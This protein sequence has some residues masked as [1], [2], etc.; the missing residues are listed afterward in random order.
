MEKADLLLEAAK[1]SL[2][3]G[4]SNLVI[5]VDEEAATTIVF[6]DDGCGSWVEDPFSE[7]TSSK[8]ED[9]GRGLYLIGRDSRSADL[10]RIG[11]WTSLTIEFD[12]LL[13]S[14]VYVSVLPAI[15]NLDMNVVFLRNRNGRRLYSLEKD[16]LDMDILSGKGYRALG[17]LVEEK[18]KEQNLIWLN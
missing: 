3:A 15:F 2:E 6:Y 14:S 8:G 10:K 13:P 7:G 11:E 18:E 12:R 17:R 9:R 1:N 16:D 4:A 5:D